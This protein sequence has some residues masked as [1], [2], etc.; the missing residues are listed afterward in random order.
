M[1]KE[2]RIALRVTDEKKDRLSRAAKIVGLNETTLVEA[3][4]DALIDYVE[5]HGELTMPL[6]VLP[7]NAANRRPPPPFSSTVVLPS[8]ANEAASRLNEVESEVALRG[9]AVLQPQPKLTKTRAKLRNLAK[10]E[11]LES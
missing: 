6:V 5:E 1:P 4:V 8:P 3:C 2:T 7:K 10:K 11:T 9:A